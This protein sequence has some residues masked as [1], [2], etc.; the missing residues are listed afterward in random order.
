MKE[1]TTGDDPVPIPLGY[2]WSIPFELCDLLTIVFKG[3]LLGF[4]IAVSSNKNQ[5]SQ[6]FFF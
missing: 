3:R 4:E 1:D 5:F 2:M 6:L